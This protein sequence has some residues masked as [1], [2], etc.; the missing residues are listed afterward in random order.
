MKFLGQEAPALSL[1][2]LDMADTTTHWPWV[3]PSLASWTPRHS[4][5]MHPQ[6]DIESPNQPSAGAMA[7]RGSLRC[8]DV[9]LELAGTNSQSKRPTWKGGRQNGVGVGRVVRG[10]GRYS[11]S[12]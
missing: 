9:S 4:A 6:G 12:C 3:D 1:F 7:M 2:G 5:V 10:D 8:V 11:L